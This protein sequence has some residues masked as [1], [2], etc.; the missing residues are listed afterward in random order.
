ME[1][2][3][4][5][6]QRQMRISKLLKR[7]DERKKKLREEF[8]EMADNQIP[9][10]MLA[11]TSVRVP[12]D[13]FVKTGLQQQEFLKSRFPSW[14]WIGAKDYDDDVVFI[15]V[16]KP[17]Y[18][19]YVGGEALQIS[20]SVS[21]MTPEIDWTTMEKADPELF[22]EFAKPVKTYELNTEAFQKK[23]ASEPGWDAQGFLARHSKHK[24]PTLRVL[25]KEN[26]DEG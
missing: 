20:R 13:F 16:K 3:E 11:R 9:D 6:A 19:S 7:L 21:E 14:N 25:A 15:L 8:F 24:P 5:L 18:V 10:H 12:K 1:T 26:K 22:K 23:M 2:L 17:E 4:F